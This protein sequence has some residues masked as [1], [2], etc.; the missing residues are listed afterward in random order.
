LDNLMIMQESLT[1]SRVQ[2]VQ[3]LANNMHLLGEKLS[4]YI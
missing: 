2:K 3:I 4:P 1:P